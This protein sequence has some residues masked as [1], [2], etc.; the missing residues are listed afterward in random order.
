MKYAVGGVSGKTG[1]A[2]ALEVSI[3][4]KPLPLEKKAPAGGGGGGGDTPP[5]DKKDPAPP[6]D[7]GKP[8][9][10]FPAIFK[11]VFKQ[12]LP[13]P[14]FKSISDDEINGLREGVIQLCADG[15]EGSHFG[16]EDFAGLGQ[17]IHGT[18][19]ASDGA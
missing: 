10:G 18:E 2:L 16:I 11:T 12:I 1:E 17:V 15:F 8:V 9:D 7:P 6:A 13:S 14:V 5:P 4:G 3:A 19:T